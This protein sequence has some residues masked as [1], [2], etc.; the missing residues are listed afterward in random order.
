MHEGRVDGDHGQPAAIGETRGKTHGVLLGD[1]DV[2][3]AVGVCL[4]EVTQARTGGH[5]RRD[6]HDAIVVGSLGHERAAEGLRVAEHVGG[7][8]VHLAAL[9]REGRDAM[10]SVGAVL[11]VRVPF[12]LARHGV[13]DDRAVVRLRPR[14]SVLDLSDIVTVDRADIGDAELLEE[15][16]RYEQ[17][18]DR[19]LGSLT[20]GDH[21][22]PEARPCQS[23]LDVVTQTPVARVEP[24]ARQIARERAHVRRDRHL[25]VVQHDDEPRPQVPCVVERLE[26]HASGEGTVADDRHDMLGPP[27]RVTSGSKAERDGDGVARMAGI[28]YVVRALGSLREAAHAAVRPQGFEALAAAGEQLVDV[29]LMAHVPDDLVRGTVERPMQAE[30]ELDDAEIGCQVPARHRDGPDELLSDLR[31]QTDEL[32]GPKRLEV[33][34]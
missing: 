32:L 8:T 9:H 29:G 10:E 12:A 18:L 23:G 27:G 34:R 6:R 26:R 28:M 22:C 30:R 15:H 5:R 1:T 13:D 11:G 17:L 4:G 14:D 33:R 31:S 19:L 2:E 7:S 16:P 3:E 25:V 24:N 20:C 21:G